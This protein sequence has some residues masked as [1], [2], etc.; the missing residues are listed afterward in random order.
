MYRPEANGPQEATRHLRD[1][2]RSF[3]TMRGASLIGD[4]LPPEDHHSALSIVLRQG[5]RGVRFIISE[6]P[7]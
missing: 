3:V 1:Y 7:L 4:S 2:S 6:V 5:P